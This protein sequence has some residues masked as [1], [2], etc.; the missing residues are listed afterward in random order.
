[1]QL[2]GVLDHPRVGHADD[3]AQN[4]FRKV[5]AAR[6]VFG[7]GSYRGVRVPADGDSADRAEMEIGE[8]V[9]LAEGGDQEKLGIPVLPITPKCGSEDP[10]R[11]GLPSLA[12][13]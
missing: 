6:G 8:Q 12:V 10:R 1:M 2:F 4:D 13:S 7:H 3:W 9:A 5:P 11:V